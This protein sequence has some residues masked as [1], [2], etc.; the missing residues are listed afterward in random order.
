MKPTLVIMAA[1]MGSRY[2]G[3]KQVD[4]VGPGG[5]T[6]IEY[7]VYDAI[8]AGFDKVVFI[9]KRE[10]LEAF[11]DTFGEKIEKHI[12]VEYVFQELDNVPEGFTIPKE[13]QKPWGTGHA[14]LCCKGLIR[15]P[16]AVINA[17]DF[18][19]RGVFEQ[20]HGFLS[21]VQSEKGKYHFCMAGFVIQN[22]LTE[23][24]SVSRGICSVNQ[25]GYLT[26]VVELTH[27][28]RKNGEIKY[29]QNNKEYPLDKD[30][31]VSMNC[32]GFTPEIFEE[33][34]SR[35]YTF[36]KDN[37][38]II[39]S[40]FYLPGVVDALIKEGKADVKVLKTHEKWYGVTYKE[41][42]Q[43]VK[44]AINNMVNEGKYPKKLWD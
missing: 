9:I 22:T 19:G 16:F 43:S 34:E 41:D 6:I 29:I 13:R 17:D 3:L 40:E 25:H 7:S 21:K 44:E 38:D 11:K 23:N 12:K 31:I 24:G 10:L 39:K 35:F 37:K 15:E 5:E 20:M 26:G 18:Y 30:S 42:K 32:W 33:L 2:G 27:I 28:E 14:V 8:K 36:L 4:P 1:G